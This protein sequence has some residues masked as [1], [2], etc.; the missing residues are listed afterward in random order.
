M[1]VLFVCTGNSFRSPVAEA[2]L[3]RARGNWEVDSAG[4]APASRIAPNAEM[5]LKREGAYGYVKRRPEGLWQKGMGDY[6]LIVAMKGEHRRELL[7]RYPKTRG[8][9]EVWDVDDPIY[10]PPGSD[11]RV[12]E[13]IKRK[14][15]E[16]AHSL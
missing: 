2:L 8:K 6:D 7:R 9:I 3:K 14:V 4:T 16:L 13:E 5:F 11:M 15:R 10:L 12:F 1:K